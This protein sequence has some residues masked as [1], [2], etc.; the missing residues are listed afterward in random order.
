MPP[1][2]HQGHAWLW[3]TSSPLSAF[4]LTRAHCDPACEGTEPPA[5]YDEWPLHASHPPEQVGL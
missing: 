1:Q 2:K 3:L 4:P 5:K